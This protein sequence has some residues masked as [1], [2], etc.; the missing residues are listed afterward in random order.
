MPM[1]RQVPDLV[2]RFLISIDGGE[3]FLDREH[4]D[5]VGWHYHYLN[6][7]KDRSN[8]VLCWDTRWTLPAAETP[9]PTKR[10]GLF[11]EEH[12]EKSNADF[13]AK[14]W[15][16]GP[17][18][19]ETM[20]NACS[21]DLQRWPIGAFRCASNKSDVVY[22]PSAKLTPHHSA[23]AAKGTHKPNKARRA[24]RKS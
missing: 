18:K 15:L 24:R 8:V 11:V 13:S 7:R 14:P 16:W 5:A 21:P 20:Y 9:P 2:A 3:E 22:P 6:W 1:I 12:G 4:H 10:R 23:V 17:T 19:R